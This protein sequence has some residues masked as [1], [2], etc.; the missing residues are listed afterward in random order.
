MIETDFLPPPQGRAY[1]LQRFQ[2]HSRT[3]TTYYIVCFSE[4]RPSVDFNRKLPVEAVKGGSMFQRGVHVYALIT[5]P[6]AQLRSRI[7]RSQGSKIHV[8]AF[9]GF[10]IDSFV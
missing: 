6:H 7:F 1:Q 9:I 2:S 5:S 10:S 4:H 3:S 8:S